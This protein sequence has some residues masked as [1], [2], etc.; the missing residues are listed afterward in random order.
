[1]QRTILFLLLALSLT[2]CTHKGNKE[3]TIIPQPQEIQISNGNLTIS[4]STKIYY[5]SEFKNIDKVISYLNNFIERSNGTQFETS[6][7]KPSSN[8]IFFQYDKDISND[9]GYKFVSD[10]NG[11]T[12]S[13]SK[14][15]GLFY[16]VQTLL[17]L[18]PVKVYSE[19]K[20]DFQLSLPLVKIEDEPRFK[21]R[22]VHLDVGRHFYDIKH[23]KE[24]IDYLAMHKISQFHWH[25]TEDQGWRI[26]IK[27]YPKLTTIGSQREETMANKTPHGGFYTQEEV[28]EIVKYATDRF[29]T[30]IPEIEMPGHSLA[31]LTAYPELSC[32]GGP[33]EVGTVWGV[34]D[35]VYCAGNE[36]TFNFL[37]DVLDEVVELFPS[38]Y[39]HIGGDECPKVRWEKCKKCQARI[40][41]ENLKNEHELQSYFIQ[42]ME[43]YLLT[44]GRSI[45]GWDEILEGGLAPQATVMSWRGE[46]GGIEAAK[47]HHNVIMTPGTHCYFDHYQ[48]D[49]ANEP[50]A[51]GGKLTLTKVYSYEPLPEELTKDEQKYI[52]GAQANLWTERLPTFKDA[53]YMLLPRLDA[54]SEVLWTQ[55]ENKNFEKFTKKLYSQLERYNLMD[56]NYSTSSYNVNIG[57]EFNDSTKTLVITMKTELPG[58]EIHYTLDGSEPTLKSPKYVKPITIE[59]S[60][61]VRAASFKDNKLFSKVTKKEI[62]LHK[63][64]GKNIEFKTPYSKR[65]FSSIYTVIDGQYG[66]K[67]YG[68]PSWQGYEGNDFDAIIDLQENTNVDSIS[69]GFLQSIGSW[70]FLP[71]YVEYSFSK[72]GK[73]FT[74]PIRVENKIVQD[75]PADIIN[76]FEYKPNINE[77]RY[78]RIFAKNLEICPAWH[79]AAGGKAWIFVDEIIVK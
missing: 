3:I 57:S 38:K 69:V 22:G 55:K 31:A 24:Y 27:K 77:T 72:D 6:K 41:K 7:E 32:T 79:Y 44:K 66:T 40:K 49:P 5:D 60:L 73:N 53:E 56:V 4:S 76:R 50:H 47:Q 15:K 20:L 43:K 33:F 14:E 68:D 58:F 30:V 42:R 37:E 71:S 63:A 65:Y 46:K 26:E 1:M 18:L 2:F 59:K 54:I 12:I 75:Y 61:T 9:E 16:G 13:A 45:I 62:K 8:F 52:L 70:I 11:I 34:F 25:L 36:K 51:F 35:D 74:N 19:K 23:I 48:G 64:Y 21:W 78:V 67:S 17:Q 29:I 39:I 10:K 28:K